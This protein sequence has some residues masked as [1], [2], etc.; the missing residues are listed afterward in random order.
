[1]ACFGEYWL[2]FQE[3]SDLA[4]PSVIINGLE[5][6]LVITDV[7]MLGRLG[8]GHIAALAVGNA[9]FNLVW[10]FIE[11]F[12]TAQDTLCSIAFGQGDL[13]AVRYWTYASLGSVILLCSIATTVF[14]FGDLILEQLFFVSPHLRSKAAL[15]VYILTPSIW[16][17]G[18]FR[19]LQKFLFA[20][21]IMKATMHSLMLGNVLNIIL[22]YLLIFASGLGFM[23]CSMATT[24][25][26][27]AMLLYL[28][29]RTRKLS[30]FVHMHAE[31]RHLV[32]GTVAQPLLDV[33]ARVDET[34][35]G[36]PTE[37]VYV[38]G[39]GLIARF[40]EHVGIQLNYRPLVRWARKWDR[41][42]LDDDS[43]EMETLLSSGSSSG[44]TEGNPNRAKPS[45]ATRWSGKVVPFEG[46]TH[47]D[48]GG[49]AEA[50]ILADNSKGSGSESDSGTENVLL[51]GGGLVVA[52]AGA[53]AGGDSYLDDINLD[54]NSYA[55][56]HGLSPRPASAVKSSSSSPVRMK[57][58]KGEGASS[59]ASAEKLPPSKDTKGH[60]RLRTSNHGMRSASCN[61]NNI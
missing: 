59:S 37:K 15:H 50:T 9:L 21:N 56:K 44:N 19:V 28:F 58:K 46:S 33:A 51:F 29:W 36:V 11:G 45:S 48:E 41:V 43:H 49:D 14:V 26:R 61:V 38:R 3:L 4:G 8:R 10:Y 54:D 53:A 12:F 31:I 47:A 17:L 18:L 6:L 39:R 57:M 40:A 35:Y 20:Q 5:S 22:N 1:M 27:F 34:V 30:S 60:L 16:F 52:A 42:Q 7:A 25:T 55:A 24:L 2:E 23:G 32:D 13:K